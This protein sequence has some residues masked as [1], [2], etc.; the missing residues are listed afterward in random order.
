MNAILQIIVFTITRIFIGGYDYVFI[1]DKESLRSWITFDT[2]NG[3]E[4]DYW[5]GVVVL[6]Y[7]FAP[8]LAD[9]ET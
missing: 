5:R 7:Y 6:C 1:Q 9:L 2:K 3:K 8:R 4:L